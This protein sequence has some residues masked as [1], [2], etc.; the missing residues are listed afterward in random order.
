[1][2]NHCIFSYF[3]FLSLSLFKIHVWC[4]FQM[5]MVVVCKYLYTHNIKILNYD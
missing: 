1:M 5:A 3:A 2:L 4:A